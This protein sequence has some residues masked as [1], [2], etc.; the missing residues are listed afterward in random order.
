M[1]SGA[2]YRFK[3]R[4]DD[5]EQTIALYKTPYKQEAKVRMGSKEA[6]FEFT[7]EGAVFKDGDKLP[8]E[9][10]KKIKEAIMQ[11]LFNRRIHK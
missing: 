6:I 4:K 7:K 8:E 1:V 10:E 3:V 2:P 9:I 11:Y 5:E